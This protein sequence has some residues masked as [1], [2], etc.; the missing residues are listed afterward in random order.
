MKIEVGG[1]S[2]QMFADNGEG[3]FETH[4]GCTASDFVGRLRK[5]RRHNKHSKEEI[6]GMIED[7]RMLKALEVRGTLQSVSWCGDYEGVIH[8][9][10]LSDRDLKSLR[11][12]G[13]TRKANLI[14]ACNQWQEADE[15][16]SK[17]DEHVDVWGKEEEK[18]WVQAMNIRKDAK[19]LWKTTLHQM[20]KLTEKETDALMKSAELL[21]ERGSMSGRGLFEN[22]SDAKILHK[23]MTPMKLSKLISVYGEEVDIIAGGKRGTFVKM[24]KSGL[25]LKDPYAYAAGFL[26]ADGYISITKRGEPR[27]GFVATGSR[28]KIH[29]EQLQKTLGCGVLQLDQK[30]Y[31]DSQ[32][33]QH[34]L[35]FYSK[36]DIRKLLT[37]ILPHLKMKDIQAKAVLAFIDETD[38]VRKDELQKLVKY[39]NWSDDT[40]KASGLLTEW[41]VASDDIAKW[42]EGL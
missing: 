5:A 4:L 37:Q 8:K 38:S 24:D 35:Q 18:A 34:R 15:L 7:V 21:A 33:S 40:T 2:M 29:C 17:L 23:S 19:K 36:G 16:L 22:L 14:R 13:D 3:W 42:K 39:S 6:D 26:D 41:G 30:I 12:F 10:G 25:I 27:A 28:G 20:D 32:R 11:K 31:K 1:L 9:F